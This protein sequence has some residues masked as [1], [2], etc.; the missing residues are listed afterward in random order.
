MCFWGGGINIDNFWLTLG[1]LLSKRE[2]I[3]IKQ[4]QVIFFKHN[5]L[6]YHTPS[7]SLS[8]SPWGD[9]GDPFSQEAGSLVL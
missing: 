9:T 3:P 2:H 1:H 5:P 4:Q 7:P 6:S 8:T